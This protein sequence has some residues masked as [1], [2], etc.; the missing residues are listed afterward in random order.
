MPIVLQPSTASNAKTFLELCRLTR[1]KCSIS[2][3]GPTAVTNQSGE[4]LRIVNWVQEAWIDLQNLY[5]T[6]D[7]MR[8]EFSFETVAGQQAYAPTTA[9][10]I[11]LLTWREDTLRS[12]R[13]P[14]GVADEQYVVEWDYDVFRNTYMIGQQTP[15]RPVVFAVRPRDKA[16]LFGSIPDSAYTIVGEYQRAARP[17]TSGTEVP[18][19]LPEQFHMLIVYGA[20]Q[21]YAYFENAPEVALAGKSMYESMLTRL[22][23]NQTPGFSLGNPLA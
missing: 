13:T 15:G 6:W 19:G 8:E 10:V 11:D 20:M 22:V 9:G 7:W 18:A 4:M 21:K 23:Q 5:S 17:F 3:N 1:E 12:Y 14:D 16:L 2:G